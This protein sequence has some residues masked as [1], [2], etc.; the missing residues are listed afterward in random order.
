MQRTPGKTTAARERYWTKVIQEA[1]RYPGGVRAYC[2]AKGVQHN[3]YYYWHHRLKPSHPEWTAMPTNPSPSQDKGRAKVVRDR[4]AETEVLEKP[5]RRQFSAAEKSR[6]LRETDVASNGQVAAI[7]RR[8]G[9]YTS[10]LQKWRRERDERALAPKRRGPKVNPLAGELRQLK[11]ANA[12]L[13]KK[14]RH[15]QAIIELQK[16]VAAILE[17]GLE[18]S[19]E[20]D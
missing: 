1:R 11:A 8:E 6:I 14:L 15:A 20:E 12:R 13:E 2:E 5:R 10:H 9:I 18:S 17:T 19:N 3:S 16:K 7:L 4:A